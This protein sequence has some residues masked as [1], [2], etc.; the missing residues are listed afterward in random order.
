MLYQRIL[1]AIPLA[2]FVVWIIFFQPGTV[3]FYFLLFVVLVS[4][5]EWAKL[6][7]IHQRLVRAAFSMVMVATVWLIQQYAQDYV[8][9]IIYVAVLWWFS[10]TYYLKYAIPKAASS[11]FRADKLFAAFIVLPAAALAMHDIHSLYQGSA[12][13]FYALSLVWV[14]D[15]GAYFSG[16]KFGKRKLA[17]NISPG[18][19]KEGLIGAVIATSV[20]TLVASYYFELDT[21]YSALLVLLSIILTFIS[22]GGD[23]YFSFLKREAG[24]KDSGNILPGHGGILDRI[25]SVLAAMPVFIVGYNWLIVT[26]L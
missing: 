25:D 19:T 13:L 20:Y 6:A 7:G 12:W 23:L 4:A 9:W 2:A 10:V 26:T 24:L 18:K 8:M 11:A 3:F 21:E 14:A 22:V 1:T 15:I 5:Y 17:P 16:K